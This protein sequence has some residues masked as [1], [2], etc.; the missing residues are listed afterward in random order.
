VQKRDEESGL[1]FDLILCL[2]WRR[3]GRRWGSVSL[4]NIVFRL[5]T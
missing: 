4:V 5:M 3:G 1:I 2:F